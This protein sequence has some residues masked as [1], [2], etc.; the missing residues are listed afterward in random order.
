MRT[1][2]R[3]TLCLIAGVV[4]FTLTTAFPHEIGKLRNPQMPIPEPGSAQ[5]VVATARDLPGGA[6]A[7]GKPGDYVL[8]NHE[9]TFVVAAPRMAG[10]YSRYGGRVLDAVLNEAGHDEDMLGEIFLATAD[11]KSLLNLRVL[12]AVQAEILSA[13]GKGKPAHLRVHTVDDRFPIVDTTI[14]IPSSPQGL[15]V[16]IDYI[17]PPD[18]PTLQIVCTLNNTT[19]QAKV[20]S[21]FWGQI[22]GDGLATYI[23]PWG[24]VDYAFQ[25]AGGPPLM[26]LVQTLPGPISMVSAIGSRLAYGFIAQQEPISQ[27]MNA[28]NIYLMMIGRPLSLPAGQKTQIPLALSVSDGDMEPLRAQMRR[29]R[30]QSD[31]LSIVHGRVITT[32]NRPV[33]DARV[34]LIQQG[35]GDGQMHTVTR[36]DSQGRFEAKVP[37]GEYRAV[38]FADGYA[39]ADVL[40]KKKTDITLQPPA[41]LQIA[42][43]DE[44]QRF[45]P[46]TLVFERLSSALPNSERVRYGEQG[47]YGRFDRVYYSLSGNETLPVEP[48]RYRITLTRGFEYEIEQRELDLQPDAR[49]FWQATLARTARLPGY[50]SGDFHVHALPSPDSNDPLADKV[51]AYAAMGVQILTATDHD[52]LT[53]YQPVIRALGVQRWI[54]SVVGCEISPNFGLG[55]FNAY[56]Q[57]YDPSKPNNGAIE[58]Y[59]LTAEQIFAAARANNDGDTI[60]QINHPRSGD[61]GYFR[62]VGLN[63]AEGT[64]SRPEQFSPN[65]DAIEVYNGIDSGQLEQTLPDWFYFLNTGHR[66]IA[67]GNTDSHHAYRLEPGFP[68]TYLYFGHEQVQRVTPQQVAQAIRSGNVLVCGGPL[69]E[70]KAQGG[71]P[72][73]STVAASEG[74]VQVQIRLAAPSWVRVNRVK[75]YVNGSVAQELPVD[76]PQDKPLN[77]Q[78]TIPLRVEKDSWLVVLAEGEGFTALYPGV[79][80][81]SFTN[82]IYIDVDGNGWQPPRRQELPFAIP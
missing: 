39:P 60:V 6:K 40:L 62:W 55:H 7:Q 64:I 72:V 73:G 23:A 38:V 63:P 71:Q 13:G 48:G 65:F 19:Q 15:Q 56:P 16:T 37:P 31:P 66:Y 34:Y 45:L 25:K 17:L 18:S 61:A 4:L 10:G 5:C 58:W 27:V 32:G 22:L 69:I 33:A 68:R 21:L 3:A 24:S 1:S 49:T 29:L 42:V 75:L 79:R 50:L 51:K 41:H 78:Q 36:T 14:R 30:K 9:A 12:R 43:R 35:D 81:T 57:R 67:I 74:M 2:M 46:C 80:P 11:E 52:V 77:W 20:Y 76:H 44:Q 26:G 47:D 70:V 53:D 59:D 82:P 54:T 28:S 8:R